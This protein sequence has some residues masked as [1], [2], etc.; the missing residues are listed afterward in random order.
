MEAVDEA[1]PE[2]AELCGGCETELRP[3]DWIELCIWCEAPLCKD[4]WEALGYCG[5]TA[6]PAWAALMVEFN[7]PATT[8]ARKAEIMRAPGPIGRVK[9]PRKGH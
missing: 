6:H 9:E 5:P 8:P 1:S 4:C 2:P 3:D 7:D